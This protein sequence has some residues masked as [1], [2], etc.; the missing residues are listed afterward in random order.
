MLIKEN[1]I[2]VCRAKS[3]KRGT[4]ACFPGHISLSR[5]LTSRG[6]HFALD[7]LFYARTTRQPLSPR[8]MAKNNLRDKLDGNE[9]DLS[10]MSLTEVPVKEIVSKR[11][12]RS[13]H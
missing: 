10:M 4:T 12:I 2:D 11:I 5:R 1:A 6:L 9:L 3:A 7:Q 13:S 8:K